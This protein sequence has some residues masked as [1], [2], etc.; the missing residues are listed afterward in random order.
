VTTDILSNRV[1]RAL[2]LLGVAAGLGCATAGPTVP[3]ATGGPGA[4]SSAA[5]SR[6]PEGSTP[7]D[8]DG[9]GK[10][11]AWTLDGREGAPDVAAYDLDGDGAPDVALSFVSG[12]LVRSELLHDIGSLPATAS[13]FAGGHLASKDRAHDGAGGPP[14]RERWKDGVPLAIDGATGEGGGAPA[15]EGA[16][17]K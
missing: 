14:V 17:R 9:D 15:P 6:P 8:L 7:H 1:T 2:L 10:P 12:R 4:R 13:T 16:R 11:D 3:H 5:I